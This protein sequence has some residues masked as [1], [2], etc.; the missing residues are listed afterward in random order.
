[1]KN[2]RT[3]AR[4]W[5]GPQ[6]RSHRDHPVLVQGLGEV[7]SAVAHVLWTAG[8]DVALQA[9]APPLAHR[10]KMA[11]ADACWEGSAV[12]DVLICRQTHRIADCSPFEV[13]ALSIPA[14]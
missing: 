4:T 10:R 8:F 14:P 13:M 11:F 9:N 3:L 6:H 12:L 1:M 7:A 5:H 2:G